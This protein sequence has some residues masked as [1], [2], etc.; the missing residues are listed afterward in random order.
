MK[1]I[2]RVDS[3]ISIKELAI[4]VGE[5][6]KNKIDLNLINQGPHTTQRCPDITKLKKLGYKPK[7]SLDYGLEKC[8]EWYGKAILP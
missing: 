2:I 5:V 1:F 7:A 8:W 4:K 6:S 3:S